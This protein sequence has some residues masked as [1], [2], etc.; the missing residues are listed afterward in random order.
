MRLSRIDWNC[1]C[2]TYHE[3]KSKLNQEKHITLHDQKY[4]QSP[5]D[6]PGRSDKKKMKRIEKAYQAVNYHYKPIEF[7]ANLLQQHGYPKYFRAAPCL[8]GSALCYLH[9]ILRTQGPVGLTAMLQPKERQRVLI[10]SSLSGPKA[11]RWLIYSKQFYMHSK[12]LSEDVHV[13]WMTHSIFFGACKKLYYVHAVGRVKP[14]HDWFRMED[15]SFPPIL[16]L[17]F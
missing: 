8:E 2:V 5:Q 6:L 9:G 17:T 14:P 7:T 10:R 13:H 12:H 11:C 3:S 16:V 4:L 15:I 1:T